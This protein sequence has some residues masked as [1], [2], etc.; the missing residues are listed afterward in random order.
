VA[1]EQAKQNEKKG[2]SNTNK[3]KNT[4]KFKDKNIQRATNSNY[5]KK[6][7]ENAEFKRKN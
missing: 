7:K 4:K 6:L 1:T 5:Y 3:T 2:K